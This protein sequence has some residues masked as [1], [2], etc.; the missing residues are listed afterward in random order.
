MPSECCC[1]DNSATRR[2]VH[3]IRGRPGKEKGRPCRQ[4]TLLIEGQGRTA[5][6]STAVFQGTSSNEPSLPITIHGLNVREKGGRLQGEE[7]V[8]ELDGGRHTE[9]TD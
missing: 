5:N 8:L 3:E 9:A 7:A 4:Q 6:E 2:E 1:V